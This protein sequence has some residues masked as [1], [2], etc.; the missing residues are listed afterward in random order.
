MPTLNTQGISQYFETFGSPERAAVM[1]IT[2]LGG[3]GT[4]WGSQVG[5]FAERYHVIVP[6][7]RGTGKT[8]RSAEG[9][10][11]KQL[12]RDMAAI[13]ED[14]RLGPIH[15]VGASTG[16]AIAQYMAL[17]HP[18]TV[19]TLTLSSTFAR[20]DAFTRREFEVRRKMAA[21]WDRSD[22]LSSY[23]LFLFSPRYTREH[24]ERVQ[25]WVD[26][27]ASHAESPEDREI[28]LKRIDMVMA[29]D[30]LAR[31]AEIRQPALVVCGDHNFCTPLPLSEELAGSIPGAELVVFKEGGELIEHEQEERYF[32]VVSGFIER[33]EALLRA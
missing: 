23:S 22:L 31:L 6:D 3:A 1:L 25:A 4:S 14:L 27:A 10:D 12:A 9:Y 8:T 20:F 26:R 29:H 33:Q 19:K 30:A 21:Q 7:H 17:D 24:P 13:V 11:T 16:G 32:E 15:V 2:G 5:R 18:Q 28:G